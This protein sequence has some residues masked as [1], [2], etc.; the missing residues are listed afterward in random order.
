MST[1]SASPAKLP[2]SV[3]MKSHLCQSLLYSATPKQ[4]AKPWGTCNSRFVRH[5]ASDVKPLVQL[6]GLSHNP[7]KPTVSTAL[8]KGQSTSSG[9]VSQGWRR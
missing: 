2:L 1:S 6:T 9:T 8:S 3:K 5:C 7:D 4:F